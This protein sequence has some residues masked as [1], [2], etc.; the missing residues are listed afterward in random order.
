MSILGTATQVNGT[1]VTT[2]LLPRGVSY[3]RFRAITPIPDGSNYIAF[4]N[5]TLSGS[6]AADDWD[7]IGVSAKQILTV[8][9]ALF[10][11][12]KD[13]GAIWRYSGT[14]NSWTRIG[15]AAYQV[16]GAESGLYAITAAK[17]HVVSWNQTTRAWD[18]IGG[19]METLM[20]GRHVLHSVDSNNIVWM[21]NG[22]PNSWMRLGGPYRNVVATDDYCIA[23][24]MDGSSVQMLQKGSTT[25]ATIGG[26]MASLR[27][28][29]NALYG[30]DALGMVFRYPG[31]G[32]I[33]TPLGGP[34]MQLMVD[35][36]TLLGHTTDRLAAMKLENDAPVRWRQVG[37]RLDSVT[38]NRLYY[39]GL[40]NG[41]VLI[42]FKHR[43]SH[44][45]TS[46]SAAGSGRILTAADQDHVDP[47]P[48]SDFGKNWIFQV[49][50]QDVTLAGYDG[51][52]QFTL[53][54]GE[55]G[56]DSQTLEDISFTRGEAYIL[57]MKFNMT[58]I[59]RLSLGGSYHYWPDHW[60]VG[61]IQAWSLSQ[62]EFYE[63]DVDDWVPNINDGHWITKDATMPTQLA[64][65]PT[66]AR[67]F[68][69][70]YF[71]INRVGHAS[72]L[73][74]DGTYISWWPRSGTI[75]TIPFVEQSWEGEGV[76]V[77]DYNGDYEGEGFT[78]ANSFRIWGIDNTAVKAWWNGF[79]NVKGQKWNVAS[80]NCSTIVYKAIFAGGVIPERWKSE[81]ESVPIWVPGLLASL[82]MILATKN[83]PQWYGLDFLGM[84]F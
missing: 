58:Q 54:H 27:A 72:M 43:G 18:V 16:I 77:A 41:N 35:G 29:A 17:D 81:T 46:A 21:Y 42:H 12:N 63:I 7:Q 73:L 24:T 45:S 82:A 37:Q 65:P 68:V 50:T 6:V 55:G 33:W 60:A 3:V 67:V 83:Y 8:G 34:F 32:T 70:D 9:T 80:Q 10:V 1:A 71:N 79:K 31:S 56:E 64:D 2:A 30:L 84:T 48:E 47:P 52:M 57:P 69:W 49:H 22:T 28:A 13:N 19:A 25:W 15:D 23:I 11:V 62:E 78:H 26:P 75:K 5:V 74:S 20:T 14:P 36:N 61:K 66:Y 38:F 39:A 44:R 76:A 53:R 40:R 4:D 51:N 59:D